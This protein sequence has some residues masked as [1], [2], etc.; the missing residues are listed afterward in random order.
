MNWK[1]LVA[2]VC[3][4]PCDP[5]DYSLPS[6]SVCEILQARVL[7]GSRSLLQGIF[8]TQG[9]NL[10]LLHCSRTLY[11]VIHQGSP[12]RIS[13]S[14]RLSCA[15]LSIRGSYS[16][17]FSVPLFHCQTQLPLL[18]NTPLQLLAARPAEWLFSRNLWRASHLIRI[19]DWE[20]GS[21][22]LS[23]ERTL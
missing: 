18:P 20:M 4:T 11:H 19:F 16:S 23:S 8:A 10:G 17:I 21:H 22:S 3:L 9:L 7:T 15:L 6:S 2:Q 12:T 5:M 14:C 1:V 13:S